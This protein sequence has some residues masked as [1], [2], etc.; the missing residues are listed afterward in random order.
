MKI[1]RAVLVKKPVAA[2]EEMAG[3]VNE[4]NQEHR[5]FDKLHRIGA[6]P[7]VTTAKDLEAVEQ[8]EHLHDQIQRS[9]NVQM[10][11]AWKA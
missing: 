4:T 1:V 10:S 3:G 9:L 5:D 6:F 11:Q 8:E 2:V 7:G